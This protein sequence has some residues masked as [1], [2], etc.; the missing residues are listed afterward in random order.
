MKRYQWIALLALPLGLAA[1]DDLLTE[2]PRSDLKTDDFYQTAAD[3]RSAIVAVY[4]PWTDGD[5]FNTSLQWALNAS[6]DYARVGPEEENP[7]IINLT[8]LD[9]NETNPY[10]SG[11][12][13]GFYTVITRANI[14]IKKVA[15]TDMD[16][17]EK[18]Y[19]LGEAHFH[20]ALAYFY[21]A[22]LYGDVPLVRDEEEQLSDP[23]R[24]PVDEVY[25]QVV[26][27]ATAAAAALPAN[28]P[29][30][31][32]GRATSGAANALLADYYLW[33]QDWAQAAA[34]AKQIIDSGEYTLAPDYLDA[35]LPGSETGTEEIFAI[36]ASSETGAPTID[37]AVWYYPRVMGPGQTGGWATMVPLD[38]HLES[39]PEG[40][41]RREVS[42]FTEGQLIDGSEVSFSPHVHKYRPSTR[43]G[44][45]DV[46]W[47]VYRYADVLLMYAEALNEMGDAAQAV[48]YVN[49]VRA[50]ARN[51]AGNEDRAE[52][53]DLPAMDQASL[54]DAIFEERRFELAFEAKRWFDLVRRGQSI[55]E[56]GLANDETA[57]AVEPHKM[58]WPVPQSQI[59]L[60]TALSQNDGY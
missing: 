55:W 49:Q 19:I 59:D 35:F 24:S 20:R 18:S 44:P 15:E 27:D 58:L 5:L 11:P 21:L 23:A 25:Q 39:Y 13:N 29:A 43:P 47:P 8:R 45:Q 51:G 7:N 54:R 14:V 1:C 28:W 4:R 16:E 9:W 30:D 40:D 46:N 12:W 36:Q 37:T 50:R 48:Q 34:H 3:A 60:N 6:A 2:S 53:A 22:R 41:Y 56:A 17:T 38:W 42:Y 32:R 10:T 33:R 52:P 57:T 26:D 31:E